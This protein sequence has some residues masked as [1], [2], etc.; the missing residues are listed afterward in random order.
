VRNVQLT[1]VENLHFI[2]NTRGAIAILAF[3]TN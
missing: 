2:K 3:F 1:L